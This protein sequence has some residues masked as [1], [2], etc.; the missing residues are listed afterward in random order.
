[1]QSLPLVLGSVGCLLLFVILLWP[2]EQDE[3]L[4]AAECDEEEEAMPSDPPTIE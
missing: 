4:Q 1:M 2:K 3:S